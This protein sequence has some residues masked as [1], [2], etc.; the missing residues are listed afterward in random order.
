VAILENELEIFWKRSSKFMVSPLKSGHSL[1]KY[2]NDI[3]KQW[4]RKQ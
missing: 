3:K 1:Y 4:V 2:L